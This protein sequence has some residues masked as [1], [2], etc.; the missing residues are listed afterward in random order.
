MIDSEERYHDI[1]KYGTM[2]GQTV[3]SAIVTSTKRLV[4]EAGITATDYVICIRISMKSASY[5][6]TT[7]NP[8]YSILN[9][10]LMNDLNHLPKNDT[11]LEINR[12][13]YTLCN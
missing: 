9:V 3:E 5:T 1:H 2:K 12:R 7:L 11:R 10:R 8:N 6:D 4:E 13:C